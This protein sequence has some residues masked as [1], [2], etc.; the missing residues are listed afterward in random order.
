MLASHVSASF[1]QGE[2]CRWLGLS[3][4]EIP[5]ALVGAAVCV[6]ARGCGG[7]ASHPVCCVPA[8]CM[9]V[10]LTERGMHGLVAG[11]PHVLSRTR[12]LCRGAY[13]WACCHGGGEGACRNLCLAAL[14]SAGPP[15]HWLAAGLSLL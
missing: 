8:Q 1:V 13:P 6:L 14:L 5:S 10:V 12:V 3:A 9:C 2:A 4:R 15:A 7:G 11:H